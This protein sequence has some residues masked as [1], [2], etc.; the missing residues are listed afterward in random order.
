MNCE[1]DTR[2]LTMDY[3]LALNMCVHGGRNVVTLV[4][5][6]VAFCYLSCWV[7]CKP[8]GLSGRVLRARGNSRHVFVD[9]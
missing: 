4:R 7:P 1:T 9:L 2:L 5:Y 3:E 6:F 8:N